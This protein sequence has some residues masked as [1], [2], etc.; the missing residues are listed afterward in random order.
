MHLS[1]V[2]RSQ[3]KTE[4]EK[5]LFLTVSTTAIISWANIKNNIYLISKS[6]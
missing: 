5:F 3:V 2:S 4:H 1:T 6:V